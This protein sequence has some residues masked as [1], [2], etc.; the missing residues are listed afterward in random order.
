MFKFDNTHIFTGYLKQLLSSVNLPMCK[1]YTKEFA[2]YF[3]QHGKEDP[4][5]IESFD[6][7]E[8][9]YDQKTS[10][11]KKRVAACVNYLKGNELCNYFWEYDQNKPGLNHNNTFWK[12]ASSIFYNSDKYIPGLTKTLNSPGCLY[13]TATHEHLGDYLRFMRDYYNINLMSLYNC[14]NNKICNNIYYRHKV[15]NTNPDF[16]IYAEETSANLAYKDS[17][18]IF[19]ARD[20][21]YHIYAFPVKLF[22]DY[23]VAIDCSYEIEMFCGFYKTTLDT[24]SKSIDLI[25][26][27]YKKVNRTF[28]KQ[29]FLYDKLN[30]KYWNFDQDTANTEGA[31][32]PHL[33]NNKVI[34]R[35]DIINREQDLKLFIKIPSSCRS[36]VV[37]LEGDFRG[38]NDFKYLP[39]RYK[40]DGSIYNPDI[41]DPS[42]TD[43]LKDKTIWE[44]Q[45]NHTV[46]N[47]G[48]GVDINEN[49]FTPIG[50]LQLLAFNTGESYPFADRLIEYLS[51]SAITPI[52]E[53]TDNIKR[54]QKVMSQ[55]HYYFKIDGLW[56]DKMQQ[57]I[58]DYM[59]N[60]GPI[61]VK[62]GVLVDRHHGLHP[63]LGHTSK[64]TLYDVLGY[65]DKEAEKWYASWT[66]ENDKAKVHDSIQNV[67]IYNGL[68][69]L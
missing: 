44:Y 50:K 27:T 32:Y 49:K 45:Q 15:K 31:S 34:T 19:D 46:L 58:Y 52:D 65:V 68:Y 9:I 39:T 47:F 54:A 63:R 25:N 40:S 64:S 37:V 59:I 13:D 22:S 2:D 28:F 29:P 62:D 41:D 16:N 36:S 53:I 57:I 1:V 38:F 43:R 20:S 69:D 35:W 51:G 11:S 4:R 17:Y 33:V 48:D 8:Y 6:N 60:S 23:T 3:C 66:K 56:E 61:E 7:I 21:K 10:S 26:K 55:N 30:V 14:F 24:S 18:R 67:D 5:V 12:G 42:S